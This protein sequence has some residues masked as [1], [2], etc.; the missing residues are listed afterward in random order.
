MAI[1]SYSV[2]RSNRDVQLIVWSN[3]ANGDS[4]Q[5]YETSYIWPEKSVQVAGTFGTGGKAAIEGSNMLDS[6]V[7]NGLT[8]PQGNLL[9]FTVSKLETILE[10]P[11]Q[12]RPNV[13]AGDGST[14]ISV[15][16]AL[17]SGAFVK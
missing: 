12:I 11:I 14:S 6:P 16:L 7:W 3:L 10:N 13:V 1:K 4:G 5:P 9:E 17:V 2:L 8:D 15:Y